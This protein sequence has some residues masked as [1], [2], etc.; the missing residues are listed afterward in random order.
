VLFGTAKSS[1]I[2]EPMEMI[3]IAMKH[4]FLIRIPGSSKDRQVNSPHGISA[5]TPQGPRPALD[6][7]EDGGQRS[8]VRVL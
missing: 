4:R 1:A 3:E 6:S 8:H 7:A 2:E 5:G